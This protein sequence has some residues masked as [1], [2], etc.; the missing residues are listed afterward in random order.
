VTHLETVT[1][2]KFSAT[3][4]HAADELLL[5]LAGNADIAAKRHLGRL[6][7][8]IH[9]QSGQ[10]GVMR[11]KVNVRNLLFMNSACFKDLI[12]WMDKVRKDGRRYQ[13]VFLASSSQHWQQRSLHAL[14]CFARDLVTVEVA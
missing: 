6:L 3:L 9:D 8:S 4:S 5:E 2:P 1:E 13:I 14:I 12:S 11:I 7:E 10:L